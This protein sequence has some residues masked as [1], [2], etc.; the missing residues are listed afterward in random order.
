MNGPVSFSLR[1]LGL[2]ALASLLVACPPP[3]APE[4][5]APAGSPPSAAAPQAV[6]AATPAPQPAP[7]A[8]PAPAPVPADGLSPKLREQAQ[9]SIDAGLKWMRA[10][11]DEAG[12]YGE[13][14]GVTAM[15]LLAFLQSHRKYSESDGPFIRRA[16]EYLAALAKPNGAIFDKN[17][18]TYNTALGIMALHATGNPAYA[19]LVKK[20]QAF[21]VGIQAAESNQYQESDKFYGGIGYGSDERPD[22]SNLQFALEA[23]AD[24]GYDGDKAVYRRAVRFLERCQNRS[25]SNDQEWAGNDGGFIYAPNE[26]KAGGTTS[27]GSMTYAGIK[28]LIYADV[29]RQ[30]PRVK[31]ALRWAH[32][33]WDLESHPGMGDTGLYYYYQTLAKAM[34]VYGE[35]SFTDSRGET[36]QWAAEVVAALIKRQS[37]EGWWQNSNPKYWEGNKLMATARAV[38]ALEAALGLTNEAKRAAASAGAAAP[39]PAAPTPA[40]TA[41]AP[42]PAA[43]PAAPAPSPAAPPAEAK[44]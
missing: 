18:P 16:V 19:E 29:D 21:L 31:D 13:H 38:L 36:H 37:P 40:A 32:E 33:H 1:G 11:Q 9:E 25:E 3:S 20:G 5:A 4:P 15:A 7:A 6:P 17:L 30:D 34:A 10:Q 28:S 41:P 14:P 24:T 22:L 43:P 2:A 44:P 35:D 12:S 39:T 42:S 8:T 26:S 23:L 27:A